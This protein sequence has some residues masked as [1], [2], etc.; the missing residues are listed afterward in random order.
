MGKQALQLGE[1][2]IIT[3]PGRPLGGHRSLVECAEIP[4][5]RVTNGFAP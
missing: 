4:T 3:H 2:S 1:H 5:E